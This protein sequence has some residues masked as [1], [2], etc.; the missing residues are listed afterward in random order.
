M[1]TGSV[2]Q[3]VALL[4]MVVALGVAMMACEAAVG[5]PGEAGK[6]GGVP[7]QLETPISDVSLTDSGSTATAT[8]KLNEHFWD[9]NSKDSLTFT[10]QTDKPAVVGVSVTGS[11]LTL[12]ARAVGTATVTVTAK[13]KED[14][15]TRGRFDVTVTEAG[16]P[17]ATPIPNKTVYKDDAAQVIDLGAYFTHAKPISYRA[18]ALPVGVVTVSVAGANLTITP[19][20]V[21]QAIVS[22]TAVADGKSTSAQFEVNV[23]AGSKPKP[24]D[25]PITLVAP[26]AAQTVEVGKTVTVN[27]AASFS[28]TE[29][30]TYTAVSS[31]VEKA[32]VAVDDAGMVTITG[33]EAGTSTIG[34]TALDADGGTAAVKFDVEV[35]DPSAPYSPDTVVIEGV[36][37][38]AD[39]RLDA[40]QTLRSLNTDVVRVDEVSGTSWK[41][42]AVKKGDAQVRINNADLSIAKT[43]AVTV[44]NTAPVVK[45]DHPNVRLSTVPDAPGTTDVDES[46]FA[47]SGAAAGDDD[48]SY[49]KVLVTFSEYFNDADG[50][51]DIEDYKVNSLEPFVVAVGAVTPGTTTNAEGIVLDIIKDFKFSFGLEVSAVDKDGAESDVVVISITSAP[52]HPDSY[53]VAQD[54]ETG[55]FE[56]V[57][58]WKRLGVTHAVSFEDFKPDGSAGFNFIESFQ[59]DLYEDEGR[60]FSLPVHYGGDLDPQPDDEDARDDV[61]D[62]DLPALTAITTTNPAPFYF[63]TA[64]DPVKSPELSFSTETDT[65]GNP[66]LAFHMESNTP[67]GPTTATVTITYHV[68]TCIPVPAATLDAITACGTADADNPATATNPE[69]DYVWDSVSKTLTMNIVPSSEAYEE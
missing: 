51:G 8:I 37:K 62:A 3:R 20:V 47:V 56:T 43:I 67:G 66:A 25:E 60:W 35:T 57:K 41:I 36:G 52:P 11:T 45:D 53:D 48:R 59:H 26:V 13:D 61:L 32:T 64:T 4:I 23:V 1:K 50:I 5:E 7:P 34:V 49:H 2:I 29:G 44:E 33:V 17:V 21:G 55:R 10:A 6:D 69:P 63:V 65:A 31:A 68:L 9:P 15:T 38:S 19:L 16:A 27:V 18:S 39:V 40:G 28:K 46:A 30:V 58:V 54:L 22:V 24:E 14:L 42:T 12:T